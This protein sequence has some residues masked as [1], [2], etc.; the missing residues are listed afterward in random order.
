MSI[1][2]S[3][4]VCS[5]AAAAALLGLLAVL[6]LTA[7]TGDPVSPGDFLP[8][9]GID[10]R[11][12]PLWVDATG[13]PSVSDDYPHDGVSAE[14]QQIWDTLA[15][16][17]FNLVRFEVDVRGGES[18]VIRVANLCRWAQQQQIT[19]IPV[20]LDQ[21]PG[22]P[23]AA[24]YP[25]MASSFVQSLIGL[26]STGDGQNL[27]SYLQ[28]ILY[29]VGGEANHPGHNG[30]M[31]AENAQQQIKAAAAGLR[32]AEQAALQAFG[33]YPTPILVDTSFDFPLIKAGAVSGIEL[34]DDAYAQALAD[35]KQFVAGLADAIDID[36]ISVRWYAG[37][38]SAGS[39]DRLPLLLQDLGADLPLQ[40][41]LGTG[42]STAFSDP[43]DQR[44]FYNLAFANLADLR[45]SQGEEATFL[46]VVFHEAVAT[47]NTIPEPA[48]G[49][50]AIASWDL[51]VKAGLLVEMWQGG[52]ADEALRWWESEV[53]AGMGLLELEVDAAGE[54]TVEEQPAQEQ[55]EQIAEIAE[56]TGEE[57]IEEGAEATAEDEDS[58]PSELG[59]A[60][61]E[62]A[63]EAA[64]GLLDKLMDKLSDE[65]DEL[66]TEDEPEPGVTG[67]ITDSD[68]VSESA[69]LAIAGVSC[70][71]L[72]VVVDQT[73]TCDVSIDNPDTA[74][75]V[76]GLVLALVDDEDYLLAEEALVEGIAVASQ[77]SAMISLSWAPL[78]TGT[79]SGWAKLYDASYSELTAAAFSPV[80]VTESGTIETGEP[81]LSISAVNCLPTSPIV[82]QTVTCQV[83]VDNSSTA[84]DA[85]ELAVALV[86]SE[87]YLLAEEALEE[88]VTVPSQ[89]AIT[90]SLEWIPYSSG[91]QTA[92]ARLYD[93][94]FNELTSMALDPVTV[95]G[96]G[97]DDPGAGIGVVDPGKVQLMP[98]N[99]AVV[100]KLRSPKPQLMRVGF[101]EI[102][103]L[104]LSS[105]TTYQTTSGQGPDI[106]LPLSNPTAKAMGGFTA[107]LMVDSVATQTRSLKLMPH[108]VRT[109]VFRDV[110]LAAGES[111]ELKVVLEREQASPLVAAVKRVTVAS[112][113]PPTR[114]V[115]RAP[116]TAVVA[117]RP[118]VRSTLPV[119]VTTAKP[120]VRRVAPVTATVATSEDKTAP[121]TATTAAPEVKTAPVTA[122]TT[123]PEVK[124][125]PVTVTVAPK[126]KPVTRA[127]VKTTRPPVT[128]TTKQKPKT[129]TV[130]PKTVKKSPQVKVAPKTVTR[131][132]PDLGL[133][134]QQISLSVRSPKPGQAVT[135]FANVRNYGAGEA[136]GVTVSFTLLSAEGRVLARGRSPISKIP[137]GRS[138]V[139]RWQVTIPKG[140]SWKLQV[141]A[142][143]SGDTSP[144]NNSS[145]I[146]IRAPAT[147]NLR[148]KPVKKR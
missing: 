138:G 56:E 4:H 83:T 95:G 93:A 119:T 17:G 66:W 58:Q 139:A 76:A 137:G 7:S 85:T 140:S 73:V 41:V 31:T 72:E 100:E 135:V 3:R 94:Y 49:S 22:L 8:V 67:T 113:K 103:V 133:S 97:G 101:P 27:E 125:A 74:Q 53:H 98:F 15:A 37:S 109:V 28:I 19:L 42:Y 46:G 128:T 80:I 124:T 127:P 47:E 114:A 145:S 6:P 26:M 146:I 54:M 55:L 29:Q 129:V 116:A 44:R 141:A 12:D 91:T 110:K 87:S 11:V 147:K 2:I 1:T 126:A 60:V 62:A 34:S 38:I 96:A 68:T 51:E 52:V 81:E 131:A 43:D 25:E 45:A 142:Q 143:V 108:Q 63:T 21:G 112:V 117:T 121:V 144:R 105:T 33:L 122:T 102:G 35:L 71:P 132:R 78:I 115:I 106:S 148:L 9:Y 5:G 61:K 48:Q 79:Q 59:T 40:L 70:A 107:T 50:A 88:G 36:V 30:G 123:A 92:W 18:E 65:V 57:H 99:P 89:S 86:D 20:L 24:D 13:F 104:S 39:A 111:H 64:I 82:D 136:R 84:A 23:L 118:A 134:S 75:A 77:S 130:A 14:L 69:G 16:S 120:Q 90:V 32:S 10:L